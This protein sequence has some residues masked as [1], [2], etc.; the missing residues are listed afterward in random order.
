MRLY[1]FLLIIFL[2][3]TVYPVFAESTY[4]LPY[5]AAMPG[6]P[7]YKVSFISE[8]IKKYWNFG[9]YG[10][11]KY[12]LAYSDKY[13][14]EAK[15]LF[16]YKQYLLAQNALLKSNIY[17]REAKFSID[18]AQKNKKPVTHLKDIYKNASE[19]HEEVLE[20]LKS[21]TPPTFLWTPEDG[22]KQLLRIHEVL[23]EAI[24]IRIHE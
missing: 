2:F 9:D 7:F 22:Q 10:A 23:N 17:F 18:S 3:K 12:N 13:L 5:P 4:V 1:L 8:K 19:K 6:N 21:D 11:F 14:V 24:S 20:Q 16:E 15:T